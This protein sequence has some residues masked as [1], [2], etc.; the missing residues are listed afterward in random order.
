VQICGLTQVSASFAT[1]AAKNKNDS[2][3]FYTSPR[4]KTIRPHFRGRAKGA[5]G[6]YTIAMSKVNTRMPCEGITAC[7]KN[8]KLGV[9]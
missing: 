8:K 1:F 3:P 4:L 5:I 9:E 2:P 6:N 7:Q